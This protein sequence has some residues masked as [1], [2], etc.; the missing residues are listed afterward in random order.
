[1][2]VAWS[3]GSTRAMHTAPI[4]CGSCP[5]ASRDSRCTHAHLLCLA[6]LQTKSDLSRMLTELAAA[7]KQLNAANKKVEQVCVLV[8]AWRLC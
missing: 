6:V 4:A 8:T 7:H 1:M 5:F 2:Q 3:H